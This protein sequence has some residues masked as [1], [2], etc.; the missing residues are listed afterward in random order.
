MEGESSVNLSRNES[1]YTLAQPGSTMRCLGAFVSLIISCT[2]PDLRREQGI[3][4]EKRVLCRLVNEQDASR[5][6]KKILAYIQG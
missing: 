1:N 6:P 3:K 4:D 2:S 5:D